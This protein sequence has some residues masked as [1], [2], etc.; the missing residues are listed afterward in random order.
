MD[1][2]GKHPDQVVV[3]VLAHTITHEYKYFK[4][5]FQ[6][7]YSDKYIVVTNIVDY[8]PTKHEDHFLCYRLRL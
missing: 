4:L 1:L 2:E 3:W 6:L 7:C 8:H 5:F